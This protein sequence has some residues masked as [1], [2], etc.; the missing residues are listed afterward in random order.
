MYLAWTDISLLT[1]QRARVHL[2]SLCKLVRS[3]RPNQ[4]R[5]LLPQPQVASLCVQVAGCRQTF[6]SV[7]PDMFGPSKS[8]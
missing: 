6:V 4:T 1:S 7:P 5:H 8:H 3:P 2:C